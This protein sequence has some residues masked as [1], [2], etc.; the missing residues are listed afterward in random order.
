MRSL[1]AQRVDFIKI[2][3]TDPKFPP[4]VIAAIVDGD[5]GR[6]FRLRIVTDVASLHQLADLG[7]TDFLHNPIDQP[8][9][10]ARCVCEGEKLTFAPT[11][12][13]I[14][15]RWFY[16]EH[17]GDSA[18]AAAAGRCI[19]AGKQ[20]LGD[21]GAQGADAV[22]ARFASAESAH[23]RADL[24]FIKAMFEGGVRVVTPA[25]DCGAEASQV[26]PSVTQ[27]H[28]EI[29]LFVE[30]GLPPLAAIR[31]A[32]LDAAPRDHPQRGPGLRVDPG[33]SKAA[34]L[35]LLDA[36]PSADIGNT[37]TIARVMMQ[38]AGWVN[39]SEFRFEISD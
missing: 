9:T 4:D 21:A 14:E 10:P 35:V 33:R 22:S 31:A 18:D 25:T 20:M 15:S 3:M 27:P 11:S 38:D 28:R 16:Y 12:P 36:D 24:P 1:K 23:A 30:A 6:A 32:T 37:I 5:A 39:I 26:T 2:W 13:N 8:V 34:D 29:Q 19:R 7:V 17:P